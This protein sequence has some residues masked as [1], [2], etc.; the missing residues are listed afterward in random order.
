MK[1]L[2]VIC[3]LLLSGM[4]FASNSHEADFVVDEKIEVTYEI[5]NRD[6]VHN[7]V[8]DY[9]LDNGDEDLDLQTY[10]ATC[11]ANIYYNGELVGT[12]TA[13]GIGSTALSAAS[14]C[15]AEAL[16]KAKAFIAAAD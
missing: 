11:Y 4:I 15:R 3:V 1:R 12:V 5:S 2:F 8:F 9:K 10:V 7:L 14:N 13:T 6:T 16:R